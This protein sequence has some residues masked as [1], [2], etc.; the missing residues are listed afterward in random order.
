MGEWKVQVVGLNRHQVR[1]RF[2][3]GAQVR[4]VELRLGS[5]VWTAVPAPGATEHQFERLFLP[6]GPGSLRV[7]LET[8]EGPRGA[9]QV[10]I[11]RS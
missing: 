4:N 11:S 1:V 5:R 2:P 8:A 3:R 9:Y 6:A 10:V 7:M